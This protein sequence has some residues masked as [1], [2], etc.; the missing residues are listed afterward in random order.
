[1]KQQKRKSPSFITKQEH[2]SQHWGIATVP[3]SVKFRQFDKAQIQCAFNTKAACLSHACQI[4]HWKML[5]VN[6]LEIK[7]LFLSKD[8]W[9]LWAWVTRALLS[10]LEIPV[11]GWISGIAASWPPSLFCLSVGPVFLPVASLSTLQQ[12][13]A[14]GVRMESPRVSQVPLTC[15]V[16]SGPPTLLE[17]GGVRGHTQQK[18]LSPLHM[19]LPHLSKSWCH[20]EGLRSRCLYIVMY[21]FIDL[22]AYLVWEK[23]NSSKPISLWPRHRP[24]T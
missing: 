16:S 6:S 15:S 21:V 13:N 18:G 2:Q 1:M 24:N 12:G 5:S 3:I 4:F 10:D 22:F 23:E 9:Q 14:L 11:P 17:S 7:G 19:P 20:G 8:K